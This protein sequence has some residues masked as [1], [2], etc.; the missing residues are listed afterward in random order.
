MRSLFQL[1]SS[2]AIAHNPNFNR[3][4]RSASLSHPNIPKQR[5]HYLILNYRTPNIPK[6]RSLTTTPILNDRF[7]N[8]FLNSDRSQLPQF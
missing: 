5:S 1:I 3:F 7:P 2:T 8:L 4:L 6:Q